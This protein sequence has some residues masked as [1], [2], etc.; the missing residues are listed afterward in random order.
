MKF[1]DRLR[2]IEHSGKANF[3]LALL[4]LG[5]LSVACDTPREVAQD[6]QPNNSQTVNQTEILMEET[7]SNI[8]VIKGH[9]HGYVARYNCY[10]NVYGDYIQI[11][12][13]GNAPRNKVSDKGYPLVAGDIISISVDN[14]LN[15]DLQSTKYTA[16][17][18]NP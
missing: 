17:F 18:T 16:E 1:I 10:L 5:L 14:V 15:D 7:F 8:Q 9:D 11:L 3:F 2:E 4:I 6:A 13:N 12:V